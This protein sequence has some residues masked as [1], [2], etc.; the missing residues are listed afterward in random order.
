MLDMC[1][2][3]TKAFAFHL[4]M[5]SDKSQPFKEI[6]VHSLLTGQAKYKRSQQERNNMRELT[7]CST[8]QALNQ[9][10]VNTYSCSTSLLQM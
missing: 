10:E 1:K 3:V 9:H 5:L 7:Q 6:G 2:R 8:N 4:G